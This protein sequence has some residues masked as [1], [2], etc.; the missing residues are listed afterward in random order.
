MKLYLLRHAEA[1]PT[2]PDADRVLT[3][4]GR[5]TARALG[6]FLAS[7]GGL[8]VEAILHSPFARARETAQIVAAELGTESLLQEVGG[9]T[10]DDDVDSFLPTLYNREKPCLVVGHNPHLTLLAGRLLT[11]RELGLPIA[12]KKG[13]L[14]T[15]EAMHPQVGRAPAFWTLRSFLTPYLYA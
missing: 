4:H 6:R 8:P 12:F 15:L 9:I 13:G 10:P 5:N 1:A 7:R 11:G 3:A 2:F 14:L